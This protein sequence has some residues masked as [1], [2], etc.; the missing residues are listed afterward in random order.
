MAKEKEIKTNAMRLLDKAKIAYECRSYEVD[1]DDLSGVHVA[2]TLGMEPSGM[3]KTLVLTGDRH[4]HLVALLPVA[5]AVDLKKLARLSG[6]KKV[7]LLPMKE[8]LPLTGYM[9]GGCSPIGMKKQFPTYID[10]RAADLD[11][12]AVSAGQRGLQLLLAPE[13]LADY[14]H[15]VFADICE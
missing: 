9:R 2:E 15:A 14:I 6:N 12:I 13:A 7:E 11:S 4:G 10:S 3:Y 1:E 5:K 8:L